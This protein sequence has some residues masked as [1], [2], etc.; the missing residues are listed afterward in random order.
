[1]RLRYADDIL[2]PVKAL[3]TQTLTEL[4]NEVEK[5]VQPNLWLLISKTTQKL[6]EWIR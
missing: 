2:L 4:V 5:L 3:I 1:M 6:S